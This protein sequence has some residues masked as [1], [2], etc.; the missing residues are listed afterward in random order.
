MIGYLIPTT[1]YLQA[2]NRIV[3]MG[4]NIEHIVLEI[5]N[6][7]VL[8]LLYFIIAYLLLKKK[9]STLDNSH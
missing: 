3:L 4:A 7:F 5:I 6:I 2:L 1:P 8:A 9:F